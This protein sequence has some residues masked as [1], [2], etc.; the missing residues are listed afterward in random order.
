M[1]TDKRTMKNDVDKPNHEYLRIIV[2]F[3]GALGA[4]RWYSSRLKILCMIE[5]FSIKKWG[6]CRK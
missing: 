6:F 4:H 2:S 3:I 1:D 5:K